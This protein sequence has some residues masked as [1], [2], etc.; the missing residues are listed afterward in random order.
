MPSEIRARVPARRQGQSRSRQIE[1][2]DAAASA[3]HPRPIAI[4]LSSHEISDGTSCLLFYLNGHASLAPTALIRSPIEPNS[5]P[6]GHD[7]HESCHATSQACP[8]GRIS[9]ANGSG[10][11]I[12]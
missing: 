12:P 2:R 7:G 1:R 9:S 6:N 10:G 8:N 11:L 4:Q 5:S 3:N